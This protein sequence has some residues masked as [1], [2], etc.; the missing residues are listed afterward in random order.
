[1]TK[2]DF[3]LFVESAWEGRLKNPAHNEHIAKR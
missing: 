3:L 2:I 1:M